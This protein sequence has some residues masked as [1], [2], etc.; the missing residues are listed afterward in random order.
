MVVVRRFVARGKASGDLFLVIAACARILESA[1]VETAH[2]DGT[3]SARWGL[4]SIALT[5]QFA[6]SNIAPGGRK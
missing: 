4:T 6:G 5:V 1:A 2:G 3:S